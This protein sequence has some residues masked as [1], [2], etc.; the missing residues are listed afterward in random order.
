ME[1]MHWINTSMHLHDETWIYHGTFPTVDASPL[2]LTCRK[3]TCVLDYTHC[4]HRYS[5]IEMTQ[6]PTVGCTER[7]YRCCYMCGIVSCMNICPICCGVK[8]GVLLCYIKSRGSFLGSA[9]YGMITVRFP[10]FF[11]KMI[12][13]LLSVLARFLREHPLQQYSKRKHKK[14]SSG[15][16]MKWILTLFLIFGISFWVKVDLSALLSVKSASVRLLISSS[17]SPCRTVLVCLAL[18]A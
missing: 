7:S 17:Y 11:K 10:L 1:N 4:K 18:V 13:C 6:S 2:Q 8:H 3:R 16:C 12:H 5:L 14:K 9:V 15:C